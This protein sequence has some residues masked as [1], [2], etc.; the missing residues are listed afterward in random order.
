MKSDVAP[1]CTVCESR[2]P[3]IE[4]DNLEIWRLLML[5]GTQWIR[6]FDGSPLGL[7]YSVLFSM[8]DMLGVEKDDVMLEKISAYER[9]VMSKVQEI[10]KE[11]AKDNTTG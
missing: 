7:N 8:A 1:D 11:S 2:C 6:S 3:A 5:G 4:D 10:S 9:A